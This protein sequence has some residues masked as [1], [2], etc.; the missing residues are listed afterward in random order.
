MLILMIQDGTFEQRLL[1]DRDRSSSHHTFG[2]SLLSPPRSFINPSSPPSPLSPMFHTPIQLPLTSSLYDPPVPLAI[3][4][5]QHSSIPNKKILVNK[6]SISSPLGSPVSTHSFEG[7][8]TRV[9]IE[10]SRSPFKPNRSRTSVVGIDV[11]VER[12]VEVIIDAPPKGKRV[13]PPHRKPVKME[14]VFRVMNA[15]ESNL[16]RSVDSANDSELSISVYSQE[17]NGILCSD[18]A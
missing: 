14:P 5:Y 4:A 9:S 1:R 16:S 3:P 17:T 6:K 2:A 18:K 11:R 7:S 13:R 10:S 15:D 12:N 8:N